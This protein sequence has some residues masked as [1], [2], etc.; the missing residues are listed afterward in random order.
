MD[1]KYDLLV[2]CGTGMG[3]SIMLKIQVERVVSNNQLPL[4]VSS[5]LV[6]SAKGSNADFFVC[7]NDLVTILEPL[8]KPVVGIKNIVNREEILE[9]LKKQIKAFQDKET[10]NG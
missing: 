1:K 7:M 8:G 2:V 6:S 10:A 5:D 4:N 3:S 9:G